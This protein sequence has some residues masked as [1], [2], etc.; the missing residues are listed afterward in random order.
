MIEIT[1]KEILDALCDEPCDCCGKPS[2]TIA[3]QP[4]CHEG[5]P[6]TAYYDRES[7]ELR[8]VCCECD[9]VA[10]RFKLA[11]PFPRN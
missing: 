1:T 9:E 11:A 2:E 5:V 6:F 3:F 7:E 8:L 4:P 10:H